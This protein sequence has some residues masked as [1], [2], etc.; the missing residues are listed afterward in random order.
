LALDNDRA[1]VQ[2]T[3]KVTRKIGWD[4]VERLKVPALHN[5]VREAIQA[6]WKPAF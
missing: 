3:D 5:D 2:A 1:G 6:G 4:R